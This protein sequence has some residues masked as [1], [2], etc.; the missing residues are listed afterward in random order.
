MSYVTYTT[1]N[2]KYLSDVGDKAAFKSSTDAAPQIESAE[3][4]IRG[5]LSG[6]IDPAYQASWVD[7][8]TTPEIIQEIA[9]K[10][11]AAFRYRAAASEDS[12]DS[13]SAYAQTLYD[14]ALADLKAIVDGEM[15][16]VEVGLVLANTAAM[17]ELHFYPNDSV[18]DNDP[19][20]VKFE[21]GMKF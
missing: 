3:R 13:V 14:E 19:D 6:F 5:R 17:S 10:L 2:S 7:P 12:P 1:V 15:D 9:A 18:D 4:I 11:A 21:M 8:T 16:I 20:G